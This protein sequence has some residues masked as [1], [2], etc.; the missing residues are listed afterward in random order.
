MIPHEHRKEVIARWR[1]GAGLTRGEHCWCGRLLGWKKGK[2]ASM[3]GAGGGEQWWWGIWRSRVARTLMLKTWDFIPGV[4]MILKVFK[5]RDDMSWGMSLV[6]LH[7]Y[8]DWSEKQYFFFFFCG[9][10]GEM[11]VVAL[12]KQQVTWDYSNAFWPFP[13]LWEKKGNLQSSWAVTFKMAV[14]TKCF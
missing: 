4:S 10:W 13:Q 1:V 14:N 6:K 12:L 8:Q 3:V 9:G 11:V 5:R 7:H 2:A